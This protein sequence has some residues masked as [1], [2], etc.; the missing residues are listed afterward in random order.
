MTSVIQEHRYGSSSSQCDYVLQYQIAQMRPQQI[1]DFGAGGGKNG[2]I[3]R[4]LLGNSVRLIAV[5]GFES[6]AQSLRESGLYDEVCHDLLQRWV[7]K[8]AGTY[9]LAIFGDVLEHLTPSE[10]HMVVQQSL[11]KFKRIIIV[12]PL[13]D[14]F[15]EDC[16]GNSLEVHR[17]YIT[18][19]FFDRYHPTEKHVVQGREWTII[20]VA[21]NLKPQVPL[22]KRI[23]W[24]AF[25]ASMVALQPIGLARP[26]VNFLKRNFLRYK[27]LLRD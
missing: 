1:V 23:S 20:N 22:Y 17:A 4:E 21:I 18:A 5:E 10:I 14:I 15:Q 8:D 12:C 27:W 7:E 11:T 6:A 9:D 25:H 2:R 16:Y 26:F 24:G 13:H 19:N 3:A